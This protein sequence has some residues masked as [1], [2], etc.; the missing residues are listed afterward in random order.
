[1]FDQE[2]CIPV[3]K[4]HNISLSLLLFDRLREQ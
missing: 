2:N 4:V 1:M 3:I